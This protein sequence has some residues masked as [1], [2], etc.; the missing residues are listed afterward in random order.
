MIIG[1]VR[2]RPFAAALAPG[3]RSR[4]S[5]LGLDQQMGA[6]TAIC[7]RAPHRSRD[8]RLPEAPPARRTPRAPATPGTATRPIRQQQPRTEDHRRVRLA[9]RLRSL[10]ALATGYLSD[11]PPCD[12]TTWTPL[13][14]AGVLHDPPGLLAGRPEAEGLRDG[15]DL[16]VGE[17]RRA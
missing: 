9:P 12:D 11:L 1:S 5:G 14:T 6:P 2:Q 8:L 10:A 4:P 15:V 13:A 7:C 17:P 3:G 16:D